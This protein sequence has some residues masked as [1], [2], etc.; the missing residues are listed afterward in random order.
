MK[1]MTVVSPHC[2]QKLKPARQVQPML[3]SRSQ[4]FHRQHCAFQSL[5]RLSDAYGLE[6]Q[7]LKLPKARC[8]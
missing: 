2:D 5:L 3:L 7:G 8:S 4:F 1:V 6:T